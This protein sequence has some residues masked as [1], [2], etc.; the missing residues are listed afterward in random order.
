MSSPEGPQNPRVGSVA[1]HLI[2]EVTHASL[3]ISF[4]DTAQAFRPR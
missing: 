3:I 1:E 4:V 2:P